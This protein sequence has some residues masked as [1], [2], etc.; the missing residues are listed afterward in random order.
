MFARQTLGP[1]TLE[2][3]ASVADTV[4]Q[5]AERKQTEGRLIA[6][7][8]QWEE[9]QLLARLGSWS[10]NIPT[11]ALTW[12]DELYRIFGLDKDAF[13][14]TH[15]AFLDLVH[16]DDLALFEGALEDSLKGRRSYD[17]EFRIVR[18]DGTVRTLYSRGQA[19]FD[20]TGKPLRMSGTA[21]DIT[22]RKQAEEKLRGS[23]RRTSVQCFGSPIPNFN[24]S[25]TSARLMKPSGA[26][27]ARAFAPGPMHSSTRFIRKI[28]R[29]CLMHARFGRTLPTSWSIA[30]FVQMARCD[31]SAIGPSRCMTL[32][33]G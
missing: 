31:G 19:I 25:F 29:G 20:E 13:H 11:G 28:A 32:R 26:A 27:P 15:Q 10:W 5:G 23:S 7:Q 2:A 1:D 9:A 30:S 16:P 4:A 14:P 8:R 3:L 33:A 22:E 6:H 21:Q 18:P 17:F 24:R 12:S